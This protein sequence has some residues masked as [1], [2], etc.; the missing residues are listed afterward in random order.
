M[1]EF[2]PTHDDPRPLRKLTIRLKAR[3]LG[4]PMKL[5][6]TLAEKFPNVD[7]DAELSE[8]EE[9]TVPDEALETQIHRVAGNLLDQIEAREQAKPAVAAEPAAL[10]TATPTLMAEP[11]VSERREWWGLANVIAWLGIKGWKVSAAVLDATSD[12]VTVG[13][14]VEKSLN[15]P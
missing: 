9:I 2:T 1:T 10:T 13:E 15:S 14:A 11:V 4:D 5:L 8:I 3:D 12:G 6:K 7:L